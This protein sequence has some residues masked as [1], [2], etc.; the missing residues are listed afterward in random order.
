MLGKSD[1][2]VTREVYC[3]SLERVIRDEDAQ[4]LK[5]ARNSEMKYWKA[6]SAYLR[7]VLIIGYAAGET[8]FSSAT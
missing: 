4:E 8:A 1:K 3:R 5:N 2:D 7:S 6:L